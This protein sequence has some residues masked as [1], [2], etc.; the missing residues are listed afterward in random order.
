MEALSCLEWV[1]ELPPSTEDGGHE[2]AYELAVT[3]EALGQHAQALGVYRELL[4]EV[5][6]SYRD[7]AGRV[8]RLRA[9]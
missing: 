6:P 2:L 5:G 3:L 7:L 1:A 8:E 9:P 4:A